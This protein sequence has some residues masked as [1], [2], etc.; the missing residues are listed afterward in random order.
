MVLLRW[1]ERGCAQVAPQIHHADDE[2]DEKNSGG[3]QRCDINRTVLPQFAAHRP[4]HAPA[5]RDDGRRQALR[6]H[7]RLVQGIRLSVHWVAP[8]A[9]P[10]GSLIT[11]TNRSAMLGVR[12]S[13]SAT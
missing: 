2:S 4:I 9:W 11:A 12:T 1:I 5:W 10:A 8:L 6:P 7:R 3:D 13:P